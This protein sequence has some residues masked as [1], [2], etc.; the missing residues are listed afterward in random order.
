M[1][2]FGT[3]SKLLGKKMG[4]VG[5]SVAC[6]TPELPTNPTIALFMIFSTV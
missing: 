4:F 1:A 2:V 3:F 5:S 6:P